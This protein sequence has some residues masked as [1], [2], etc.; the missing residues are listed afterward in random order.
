M[1]IFGFF[2]LRRLFDHGAQR[3]DYALDNLGATSVQLLNHAS[4]SINQLL[5]AMTAAQ[6]AGPTPPPSSADDTL[7]SS[8]AAAIMAATAEN[9][10]LRAI[11]L[12]AAVVSF[13]LAAAE[14]HGLGD[15][16]DQVQAGWFFFG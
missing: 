14:P 10:T 5:D 9:D 2:P 12:V 3:G 11:L 15:E 8:A 7:L 4:T 13:A 16:Q 6:A 1:L